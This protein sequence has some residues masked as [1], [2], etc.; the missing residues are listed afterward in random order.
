MFDLERGSKNQIN[1]NV[2]RGIVYEII[3]DNGLIQ[4]KWNIWLVGGKE[5]RNFYFNAL[6]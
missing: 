1:L 3:W 2:V 5:S 4:Y 6:S